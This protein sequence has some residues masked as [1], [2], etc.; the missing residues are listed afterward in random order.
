[1]KAHVTL[2]IP[3]KLCVPDLP[4]KLERHFVTKLFMLTWQQ[5]YYYTH[6]Y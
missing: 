6:Y 4:K 5:F 1:M 2:H 3:I